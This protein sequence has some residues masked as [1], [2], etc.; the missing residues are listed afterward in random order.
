MGT[1]N[2]RASLLLADV[3]RPKW[4]SRMQAIMLREMIV[5]GW[6]SRAAL[7][8]AIVAGREDGGPLQLSCVLSRSLARLR[9][10]LLPGW[11]IERRRVGLN[12]V[13]YR[14]VVDADR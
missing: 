13:S 7:A 11:R 5:Y 4:L 3:V 10:R 12:Q 14:L 6:R 8:D 9:R 2:D 1:E